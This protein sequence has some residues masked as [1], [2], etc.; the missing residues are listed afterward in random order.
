[1]NHK[2]DE[3]KTINTIDSI[4]PNPECPNNEYDMIKNLW[5]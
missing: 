3:K 2:N 4:H 1:M 5:I